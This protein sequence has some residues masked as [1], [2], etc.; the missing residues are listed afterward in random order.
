MLLFLKQW[1]MHIGVN[2]LNRRLRLL[3]FGTL[4]VFVTSVA[5]WVQSPE[6]PVTVTEITDNPDHLKGKRISV[7]GTV[8]N[9][10]LNSSSHNFVIGDSS[11]IL[12][13]DFAA[14]TISDAFGEGR[15]VL[16]IGV[17]EERPTGWILAAEQIQVG[18][19]SKYEIEEDA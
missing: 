15:T 10:T 17:L 3:I 8:E 19:P 12:E 6:T 7:R 16:I 14:T 11:S 9:G 13:V 5:F 2:C 18:C 1:A 4:V